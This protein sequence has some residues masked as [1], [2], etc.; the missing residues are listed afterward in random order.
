MQKITTAQNVEKFFEQRIPDEHHDHLL[1]L[2]VAWREDGYSESFI[3]GLLHGFDDDL[4]GHWENA[5]RH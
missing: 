3:L 5:P 4:S 1:Q 2:V